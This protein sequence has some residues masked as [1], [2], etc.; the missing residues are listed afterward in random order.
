MEREQEPRA[1]HSARLADVGC[2]GMSGQAEPWFAP[3]W[4]FGRSVMVLDLVLGVAVFALS[5]WKGWTSV[6][7][8]ASAILAGGALYLVIAAVPVLGPVMAALDRTQLAYQFRAPVPAANE[9]ESG[10]QTRRISLLF[11]AAGLLAIAYGVAVKAL[12]A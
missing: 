6:E 1:G 4:R 9:N 2:V 7:E 11:V 12:F 3:L 10:P 5:L 8:S